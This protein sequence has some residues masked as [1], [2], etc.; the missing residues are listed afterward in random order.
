MFNH[1]QTSTGCGC[2]PAFVPQPYQ[3]VQLRD[4]ISTYSFDQAY[5][6]CEVTSGEWIAWVPNYGEARLRREQLL[7]ATD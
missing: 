5:L 7:Q 6:L 1:Y 4:P 2:P 3:W